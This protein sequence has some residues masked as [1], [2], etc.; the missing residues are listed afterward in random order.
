MSEPAQKC[1]RCG[2]Q[3][4]VHGTCFRR[5]GFRAEGLKLLSLSFQFSEIS[6]PTSAW[7]C[8]GCG[9]CWTEIDAEA[10]KQKLRDLGD[11]ELKKHLGLDER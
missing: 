8:V 6:V 5:A 7:A 11:D 4:V 3:R 9:L 10:L 1:P 2:D